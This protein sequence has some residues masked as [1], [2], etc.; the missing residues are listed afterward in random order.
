ML[1][2]VTKIGNKMFEDMPNKIGL[3]IGH[4]TGSPTCLCP[5]AVVY[6]FI[7]PSLC[8]LFSYVNVRFQMK[9]LHT[10]RKQISI[11]SVSSFLRKKLLMSHN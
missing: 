4:S 3:K 7:F 9:M 11:L 10:K 5:L 2:G 1:V 6:F 8:H